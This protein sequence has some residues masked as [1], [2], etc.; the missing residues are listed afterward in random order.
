MPGKSAY[1]KE[2]FMRWFVVV[3]MLLFVTALP[4]P[5]QAQPSCPGALPLR[6]KV[7]QPGKVIARNGSNVRE[8]PSVSSPRVFGMPEGATFTVIDG[9]VCADGFAWWEVDYER[10]R[11][12]TAEGNS[13]DYWLQSLAPNLREVQFDDVLFAYD[14]MVANGAYG[15]YTAEVRASD[16]LV[17]PTGIGFGFD[18]YVVGDSAFLILYPVRE[19]ETLNPGTMG[20]LEAALRAQTADDAPDPRW[21]PYTGSPVRVIGKTRYF[22]FQSGFGVRFLIT[23]LPE[24]PEAVTSRSF[25]YVYLGLTDDGQRFVQAFFPVMLGLFPETPDE[26]FDAFSPSAFDAYLDDVAF[27][28]NNAEAETFNPLLSVLDS[29]INTLQVRLK[30]SENSQLVAFENVRFSLD[31]AVARS[32]AGRRIAGADPTSALPFW[33]KTP[34]HI[35]FMLDGVRV[36]GDMPHIAVYPAQE[37]NMRFA[38]AMDE[39]DVYL[40]ARTDATEPPARLP[41]AN[42]RRVFAGQPRFVEFAGGVGVRFLAYLSDATE[43][44]TRERINYVFVALTSDGDTF[45]QV[46]IPVTATIYPAARPGDFNYEQFVE[47]YS[48]YLAQTKRDL[49]NASARSFMPRLDQLDALVASLRVD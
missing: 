22:D 31:P 48:D 32:A 14:R 38:G 36:F 10:Q 19:Y 18:R 3:L 41:I 26:N 37:Y 16:I 20:T 45:I 39:L 4:V 7:N 23:Y 12:W 6:M 25:F 21:F 34:E 11:G 15:G 13:S 30:P 9:P 2:G 5:V 29:M 47:G 42:A 44:I 1:T 17:L 28:V 35:Q 40:K 27:V 33:Q 46:I 24:T 43:F 8:T 49:N